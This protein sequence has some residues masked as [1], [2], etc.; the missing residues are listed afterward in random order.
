MERGLGR[1]KLTLHLG[2]EWNVDNSAGGNR[3]GRN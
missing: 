1:M 3:Q 2:Q